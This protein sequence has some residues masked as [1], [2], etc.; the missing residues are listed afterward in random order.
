MLH[1]ANSLWHHKKLIKDDTDNLSVTF[2]EESDP[3]P[4]LVLEP[5]KR[6]Y[7]E[8][9]RYRT[10]KRPNPEHRCQFCKDVNIK[11]YYPEFLTVEIKDEPENPFNLVRM[12]IDNKLVLD[13]YI[14]SDIDEY[15]IKPS[16]CIVC[17]IPNG[18]KDNKRNQKIFIKKKN[19]DSY[20]TPKKFVDELDSYNGI[21]YLETYIAE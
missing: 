8:L 17:Y 4:F 18:F 5:A 2:K 19:Y 15:H 14:E 20:E 12:M 11:Y 21:Q 3:I 7:R 9:S 6:E 13:W 10:K 16:N 1:L